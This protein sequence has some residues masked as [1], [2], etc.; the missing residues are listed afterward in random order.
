MGVVGV[1]DAAGSV[2]ISSY[3]HRREGSDLRLHETG[4]FIY[5]TCYVYASSIVRLRKFNSNAEIVIFIFMF[6][7]EMWK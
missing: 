3:G 4:N 1:S 7:L 2:I 6:K 5:T